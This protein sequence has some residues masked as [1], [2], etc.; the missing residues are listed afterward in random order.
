MACLRVLLLGTL[1][2]FLYPSTDASTIREMLIENSRAD[3][4]NE[5]VQ[6]EHA[7]VPAEED[8][9]DID[10]LDTDLEPADFEFDDVSSE[11]IESTAETDSDVNDVGHWWGNKKIAFSVYLSADKSLGSNQHIKF[12]KVL[13][14]DG[15]GYEPST[16]TFRAPVSG[17]YSFTFVIAQRHNYELRTN[18][19]VDGKVTIGA[20]AEGTRTYHDVQG[21][22]TVNVHVCKGKAVWVESYNRGKIEG[23]DAGFRYT[24]F[25]GHILYERK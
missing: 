16:G 23:N 4:S 5:E 17:V 3:D 6:T 12:D 21:T 19:V 7:L 9:S 13:L 18:L 14:N 10:V 25:S 24:S 8:T 11:D 2:L 20:I 1:L 15:N 22:N